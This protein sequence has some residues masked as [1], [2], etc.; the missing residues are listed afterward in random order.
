M[1]HAPRPTRDET[2]L[3]LFAGC[4]YPVGVS[5][6]AAPAEAAERLTSARPRAAAALG[7]GGAAASVFAG[8]LV[9]TSPLISHSQAAGLA[10]GVVT[11]CY[12]GIGAYIAS[13]RPS[14]RLGPLIAGAGFIYSVTSLSAIDRSLPFT[15]GRVALAALVVYFAFLFAA[16]PRGRLATPLERRFFAAAAAA[17]VAVWTVV[18][19]F[20]DRLPHGGPLTDC[21]TSCPG[22][23]LQL[24]ETPHGLT[25]AFGVVAGSLTT[26]IV[27]GVIVIL[28]RK[29]ASETLVRRRALAPLL[30]A[31]ILL[32]A[33][34]GTYT[35]ISEAISPPGLGFRIAAVVGALGVPVALLF[36]QARG[37]LIAT[38]ALWREM[39][40]MAPQN[41]TP[42]WLQGFLRETLGDP[43]FVLAVWSDERNGYVDAEGASIELPAR[44]PLRSVTTIARRGLPS[45]ALIHDVALDEDLEVVRG[46]GVTA[47]TLLENATLVGDL[48]ASRAR[49]V[50]SA[51][52]ERHRLERDLHDGAQQRLTA[53]QLKLAVASEEAEQAA[54]RAELE[55][56]AVEAA[57]VAS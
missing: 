47:A 52:Q 1:V 14:S 42:L 41:V 2:D 40:N 9:W 11:A 33:T 19:V 25:T 38:A 51:E 36:G 21:A 18:L 55:Q 56:L 28:V 45:L 4:P 24:V 31:S 46:L 22:N 39:A 27:A 54:L 8:W 20:A 12:I 30:Y 29:A 17:T 3:S 32:A 26:L 16:F 44:T 7:L 53:I 35:V 48:Q 57:A 49:I 13:L 10:K 34:Y 5:T 50:D 43:S 23:A 15:V 37:R 6:H